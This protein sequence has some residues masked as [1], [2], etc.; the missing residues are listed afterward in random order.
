MESPVQFYG[1]VDRSVAAIRARLPTDWPCRR[2]C[3][4]CCHHRFTIGRAEWHHVRAA[5]KRL[6]NAARREVTRRARA[7][8]A[9]PPAARP[10]CPLLDEQGACR[11]Y[12]D[13]P[14]VCRAFGYSI[15]DTP[16][17][18]RL[19]L[20]CEPLHARIND[21][22]QRGLPLELADMTPLARC[23]AAVVGPDDQ[24]LAA[25][26]TQTPAAGL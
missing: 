21:D 16:G 24:S 5:I 11:I 23:F 3:C 22:I 19:A 6:P 25:W 26:I 7:Y 18:G 2:G 10:P 8:L 9:E 13:R 17:G 4:A 14:L 12:A 1:R 20:A 15:L